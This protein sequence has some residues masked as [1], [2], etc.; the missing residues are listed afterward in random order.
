MI[1]SRYPG[2]ILKYFVCYNIVIVLKEI[3]KEMKLFSIRKLIFSIGILSHFFQIITTVKKKKQFFVYKFSHKSA[4]KGKEYF[5]SRLFWKCTVLGDLK[6]GGKFPK[7]VIYWCFLIIY[8]QNIFFI[9]LHV[10]IY[11][12]WD[13]LIK[14]FVF[15]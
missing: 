11:S 3:W 4:K 9:L 5:K 7:Q 2:N 14:K 10:L 8:Y 15:F 12:Y 1:N 6:K 13:L